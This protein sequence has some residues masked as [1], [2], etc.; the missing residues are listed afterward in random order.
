LCESELDFLVL[1][2]EVRDLVDVATTGGASKLHFPMAQEAYLLRYQE[3]GVLFD[4]DKAGA[5]GMD[6]WGAR[7]ARFRQLSIP[8]SYHDVN[9]AYLGGVN[10]RA[11]VMEM[12][13]ELAGA[14]ELED[15]ILRMIS[16]EQENTPRYAAALAE[17]ERRY[18][19][20]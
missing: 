14:R 13:P 17:W 6:K 15:L 2:Q 9:A 5:R 18:R 8:A 1:W 16:T 19:Y 10:L 4:K 11:W 7:G 20:E 3:I 12:W